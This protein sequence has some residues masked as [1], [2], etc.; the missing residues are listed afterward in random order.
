MCHCSAKEEG[1]AVSDHLECVH[2]VLV[3]VVNLKRG[4]I[5]KRALA[6]FIQFII[7]VRSHL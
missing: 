2:V 1:V 7:F 5:E 6:R 4:I 3:Q